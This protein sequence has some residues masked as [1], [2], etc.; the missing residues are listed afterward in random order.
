MGG[1]GSSSES[2]ATSPPSKRI[3]IVGDGASVESAAEGAVEKVICEIAEYLRDNPVKALVALELVKGDRL[4][5]QKK[6]TDDDLESRPF[7]ETYT[8]LQQVPISFL[9]T[10]IPEVV[11]DFRWRP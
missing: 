11:L 4:V 8:T 7:H 3:R 9:R 5:Y 10:F 1:P 6:N 2:T